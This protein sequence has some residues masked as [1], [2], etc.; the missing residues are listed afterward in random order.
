MTDQQIITDPDAAAQSLLAKW[1]SAELSTNTVRSLLSVLRNK[2]KDLGGNLDI[3]DL[4][5]AV[6]RSQQA[7]VVRA[8]TKSEARSLLTHFKENG[9]ERMYCCV[10]LALHTGM[11]RGEIF[12]LKASD[13][14]FKKKTIMVQRSYDGPTKNGKSRIVPMS[15]EIKVLLEGIVQTNTGRILEKTFDPNPQLVDGCRTIGISPIRFHDLRHT[16]ATL[17]LD[18]GVS[19]ALIAKRLGHSSVKTTLDIYWNSIDEG[20]VVDFLP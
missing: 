11:R 2:V 7:T 18:A 4:S 5:R 20:D 12:G 3:S 13:L 19:P 9:P 10:L 16:Y 14:N 17:G 15:Q 8:L 1:D 6:T